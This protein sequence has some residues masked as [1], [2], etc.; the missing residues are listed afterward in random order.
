MRGE[1]GRQV[2]TRRVAPGVVVGQAPGHE[3]LGPIVASGLAGA[4]GLAEAGGPVGLGGEQPPGVQLVRLRFERSQA[5]RRGFRRVGLA[6]GAGGARERR[7]DRVVAAGLGAH[8]AEIEQGGG[9]VQTERGAFGQRLLHGLLL[10]ARPGL[11]HL[12]GVDRRGADRLDQ[13]RDDRGGTAAAQHQ[14]GTGLGEACGERLEA[15]VQP[16]SMR[17]AHGPGAGSLVVEHV[18]RQDRPGRGRRDQRR[19]VSEAQVLAEPDDR[20]IH[21]TQCVVSGSRGQ[22]SVTQIAA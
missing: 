1:H 16:P 17:P 4:P 20:A 2:L 19:V 6:H 12:A 22:C 14:R 21:S 3:P 13:L 18:D 7:E 15:M 5:G 11:G 10:R 9:A 8:G